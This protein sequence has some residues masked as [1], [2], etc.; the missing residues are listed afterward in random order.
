MS[1]HVL[2]L[3]TCD[4]DMTSRG[5]FRWPESGPVEAPDW[6]HEPTCGGGLHGFLWG[7]GNGGLASWD[8]D[9][10][11]LVVRVLAADV[12][13]LGDKVKFPRGDVVFIGDRKAA[14]DYIIEHGARGPV[15]GCLRVGGYGSTVTGGYGSTVTGGDDSTVTG[16]DCS[17]V[18]GGYGSTVT[19][20]DDSTVTGGD[21]STLS[22]KWWDGS[23]HRIAVAYVSEDGIEANV[24]YRVNAGK[25]ERADGSA[26]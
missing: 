3:R 12:V 4:A 10:R 22:V 21:Y 25:F 14:T 5:G 20:G 7:E 15:I 17:T 6:N 13:D 23:R 1:D 16:G 19:G 26:K 24:P 8:D 2:I 9:A 18:T 11:W